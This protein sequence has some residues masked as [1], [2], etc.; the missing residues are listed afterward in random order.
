MAERG[1]PGDEERPEADAPADPQ[2]P[3]QPTGPD[4]AEPET[5]PDI[6]GEPEPPS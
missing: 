3:A 1:K 6:H 4:D 2:P 5:T